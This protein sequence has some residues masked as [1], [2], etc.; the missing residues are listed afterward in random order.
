MATKISIGDLYFENMFNDATRVLE[1][2]LWHNN[3]PVGN[4]G[5]GTDGRYINDLQVVQTGLAADI[6]AGDF[7]GAQLADVNK[8][9]AD[10][11]TAI[12]NVPG[13]V[14]NNNAA[15]EAALRTAHLDIINTIENDATLQTLSIKDDNPGFNFAPPQSATSLHAMPHRLSPSSAPS[16]T[17]PNRA[18]SAASTPTTC[19]E[20]RPICRWCTTG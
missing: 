14:N 3:V 16:S 9:M 19:R 2:G 17:T 1:G 4:Q 12:A 11:A 5:N 6:A 7:S 13:A 18:L 8:V 15:A 20:F 10:I